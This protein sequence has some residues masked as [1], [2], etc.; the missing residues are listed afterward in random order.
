MIVKNP[1]LASLIVSY[2]RL[3]ALIGRDFNLDDFFVWD[4]NLAALIF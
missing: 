3:A 4:L 2:L 1:I